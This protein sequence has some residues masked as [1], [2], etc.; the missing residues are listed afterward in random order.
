MRVFASA[1]K[2]ANSAFEV[3]MMTREDGGPWNLKGT[4]GGHSQAGHIE[5]T[6]AVPGYERS[7]FIVPEKTDIEFIAETSANNTG[8]SVEW[9]AMEHIYSP[10]A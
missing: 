3:R 6:Y 10:Y 4:F 7:G 8:I 9:D 1:F 2:Q 5:R